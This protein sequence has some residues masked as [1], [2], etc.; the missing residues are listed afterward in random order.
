VTRQR[1]TAAV[2]SESNMSWY[3]RLRCSARHVT[4]NCS[5]ASCELQAAGRGSRHRDVEQAA[6]FHDV[7]CR[8]RSKIGGDAAVDDVQNKDRPLPPLPW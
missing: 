5:A 3:R 7:V 1:F 2:G 6:F 4:P 8:S